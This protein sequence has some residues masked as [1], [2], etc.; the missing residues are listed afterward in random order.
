[1][2]GQLADDAPTQPEVIQILTQ[3]HAANLLEANITADA[4]VLL[5][6]HKQLQKRQFQG[7]LMNI[8]FPRIPL[9][10]PD[11]FLKKWMPVMN[12]I[13]SKVGAIIWLA[14]V[15][16]AVVSLVPYWT[17]LK[18]AAS[19]AIDAK[20]N[21]LNYIWLFLTFCSIKLIHELGHAFSCRR[22]GGEVHELG[23]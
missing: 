18:A 8:M 4:G 2:G 14:V 13:L 21:S 16:G 3:L 6:R 15:I 22:F 12:W 17:D 5:R 20:T 23:T 11:R 19:H 10:D 1:M 7:K 9:W